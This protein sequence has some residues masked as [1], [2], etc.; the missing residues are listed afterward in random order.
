MT[1][2]NESIHIACL[3]S[4]NPMQEGEKRGCGK[5]DFAGRPR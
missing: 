1:K 3:N 5:V 2:G 4:D